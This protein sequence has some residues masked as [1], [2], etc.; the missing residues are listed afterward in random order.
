V[1]SE[2]LSFPSHSSTC[3]FLSSVSTR[4]DYI[5]FLLFCREDFFALECPPSQFV[6][7]YASS[8]FW[9][10]AAMSGSLSSSY[11]QRILSCHGHYCL[12]LL[13]L[14][15]P[16]VRRLLSHH[17]SRMQSSCSCCNQL[18]S[19]ALQREKNSSSDGKK[20]KGGRI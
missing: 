15:C 8:K 2:E 18:L 3:T 17:V 1:P 14:F 11:I 9:L 16:F 6:G 19:P 10:S 7:L 20:M 12:A 4:T 13:P 5:N